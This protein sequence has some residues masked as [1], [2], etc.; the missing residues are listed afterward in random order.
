MDIFSNLTILRRILTSET[1]SFGLPRIPSA[2]AVVHLV[3]DYLLPVVFCLTNQRPSWWSGDSRW[4]ISST[5]CLDLSMGSTEGRRRG[6]RK[7]EM[8]RAILNTSMNFVSILN[9]FNCICLFI[10]LSVYL[11]V[12]LSVFREC[13]SVFLI[14]EIPF[15]S[16]Y[17]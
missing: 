5:S 17:E 7:G 14:K 9:T 15:C 11:F 13:V 2:N 12:C 10:C 1:S 4:R 6:R 16:T 8:Q 3:L